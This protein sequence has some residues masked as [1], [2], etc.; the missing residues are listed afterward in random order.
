MAWDTVRVTISIVTAESTFMRLT[1]AGLCGVMRSGLAVLETGKYVDVDVV[2][3]GEVEGYVQILRWFAAR[4]TIGTEYLARL[5][6]IL[7][8]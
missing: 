6:K 5:D 1:F 3:P 7:G 4:W 2:A 8:L